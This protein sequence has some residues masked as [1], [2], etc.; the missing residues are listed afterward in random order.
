MCG[1]FAYIGLGELPD[2]IDEYFKRI[3][4]RGPDKSNT[5]TI[6][7]PKCMNRIFLGF[8]R[9]SINDLS[10]NGLQPMSYIHDPNCY[11]ICNGEIYNCKELKEKYN[12]ET[13]SN[14]DC[15]IILHMY[16]KF[17]IEETVKQL[18]GVFAFIIY[19][20]NYVFVGR[21]IIGVRPLFVGQHEHGDIAF[22]SEAKSLI[23]FCSKIDQFKPGHFGII[24]LREIDDIIT[25]RY[26]LFQI[27]F[28]YIPSIN[29]ELDEVH[30]IKNIK[31]NLI[32]AVEKRLM[33]DRP[34]GCFLSGGLD[35][36]IIC[37]IMTKLLDK[38][39]V[40]FSIGMA[41]SNSPD[42][43]YSEI[44]SK[45][46]K[47]D[48]HRVEYTFDEGFQALDELIYTLETYDITTIR[49]S[50]PQYL[51]SKYITENTDIRVLFSGEGPDEHFG[52]YQYLQKAPSNKEL[53]NEL[54]KLTTNLHYFDVLR[55]D[56]STAKFGLEVRVPFL[57]KKFITNSFQ[58]PPEYKNS[59]NRIEKWLIRTAFDDV[60]NPFLPNEIL[61][62]KKNAFSDAVGYQW[63][64]RLI[65]KIDTLITDKELEN[66]NQIY[67]H[68]PPETKEG[69]YYRKIFNKHYKNKS[70][71]IPYYWMPNNNWFSTK[72]TDPSAKTLSCFSDDSNN[73][74]ML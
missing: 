67:I 37:A 34:V 28:Y 60:E 49:A 68:N 2:N 6:K 4:Y 42:L 33:S 45:F 3:Q 22:A 39:V 35:S 19:D 9:L 32:S 59:N 23:P 25:C 18:D 24:D 69:L 65:E 44:V 63:V 10:D 58:T 57:D 1:I 17:G 62:R 66:A 51:L 40:T 26:I 50:L 30:V 31:E 55:T 72:I 38:P 8:H 41:D 70:K 7:Y 53:H 36:S 11:L 74:S 27:P 29:K 61:W 54:I 56:R 5:V 47:T 13:K 20:E 15:E 48:H 16:K 21:D 12:F 64:D 46:L 71:L 52:G 73:T 14:S 43:H